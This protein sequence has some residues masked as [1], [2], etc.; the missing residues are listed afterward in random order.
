MIRWSML[1]GWWNF[2]K[3]PRGR[4]KS[5]GAIEFVPF[6]GRKLSWGKAF[7]SEKNAKSTTAEERPAQ[8]T[9]ILPS[10]EKERK[11]SVPVPEP[12]DVATR[13]ETT[14][15][16]EGEDDEVEDDGKKRYRGGQYDEV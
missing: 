2:F 1:V 4:R 16:F 5:S 13:H 7:G 15:L 9:G 14:N 3:N 8:H 12:G 11:M 6:K 10:P